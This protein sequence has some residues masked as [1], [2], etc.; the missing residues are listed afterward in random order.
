[1]YELEDYAQH[2]IGFLDAEG[3]GRASLSG[4]S[5]GGDVAA[6]MAAHHADRVDRVILN[7]GAAF[8]IPLEVAERFTDLSM[9]AVDDPSPERIRARLE[10]SFRD[11]SG[12]NEDLVAVRCG[13]YRQPAMRSAMP[14]ILSRLTDPDKRR[15]N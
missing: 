14:R 11:P 10:F 4:E 12:V 8:A 3:I 2:L 7:T 9:A 1:E 15:R 6:W 5:L 13:I